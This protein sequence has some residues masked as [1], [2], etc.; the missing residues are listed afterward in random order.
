MNLGEINK[1]AV[2]LIV[3]LLFGAAGYLWY[4]M[5]YKPAVSSKTAAI[6]AATAAEASLASAKQQLAAAQ[7]AIDDAKKE[8][9]KLD[10]SVARLAKARSAIPS[11][12]LI[13]DAA[14][15][16]ME[17][18]ER[19]GVQTGYTAGGDGSDISASSAPGAS[20]LDGAVPID[21][22]F[23]AAGT[24]SEMMHFMQ[25]VESSV[26]EKDD[27]LFTRGRLFNVVKLEIGSEGEDTNSGGGFTADGAPEPNDKGFILGP[28]DIE[29][30]VTVRM[31]TTSTSN[32]ETV[33][34]STPDPAASATDPGASTGTG[35]TATDPA[36]TGGTGGATSTDPAATGGTG[37][38]GTDPAAT[39]GTGGTGG[40]DPA[41]ATTGAGATTG[42]TTT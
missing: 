31:Y 19:S 39:G 23:E 24:Y 14:I 16:H 9:S 37:G 28:N 27:K 13:D 42:G 20:S 34:T 12:K 38:A 6:T 40:T 25:L 10:D 11:D 33:G 3:A 2:V 32:A 26:E 21:L 17:Y 30:T 8:T 41:A 5:L 15:A 29:F 35:A 4:S 22:E 7:Q 18:A 36:A 1:G